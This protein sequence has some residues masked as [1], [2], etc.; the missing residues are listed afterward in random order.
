MWVPGQFM[1]PEQPSKPGDQVGGGRG[2]RGGEVP[3]EHTHGLGVTVAAPPEW[4]E[5]VGG[6]GHL[7]QMDP[8]ADGSWGLGGWAGI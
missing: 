8:C 3:T 1:P 7:Y 6:V 5:V 4:R 2:W